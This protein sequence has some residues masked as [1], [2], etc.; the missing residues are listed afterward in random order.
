MNLSALLLV[1]AIW[2]AEG[3]DKTRH[4]YGI[5]SVQTNDPR[6][7]CLNTVC[8]NW[9]RWD[10]T[11]CYIDFLGDRYCPPTSDPVGNARWKRNVKALLSH[12]Q[13]D[14]RK[15]R[16]HLDR[17]AK[18]PPTSEY[19]ARLAEFRKSKGAQ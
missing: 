9:E 10:G 19:R 18:F 15:D 1:M 16:P 7:V 3:G 5:L 4:P 8:N 13:C 12:E 6:R 2:I 14:C 17:P 11:G